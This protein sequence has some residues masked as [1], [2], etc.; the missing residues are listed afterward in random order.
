MTESA[1]LNIYIANAY[2]WPHH[3]VVIGD[4]PDML[5]DIGFGAYFIPQECRC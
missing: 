3:T 5:L 4:T 2:E 1:N